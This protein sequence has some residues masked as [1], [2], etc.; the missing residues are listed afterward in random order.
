ME[1]SF[2][3]QSDSE[4]RERVLMAAEKLFR[5]RGYRAVALRD[6]AKVIGIRHT[7]LYHHF[8]QGKEE[9]FVAVTARRMENYRT[10]LARAIQE[11]GGDWLERLRAAANWLLAQE[12]MHLGRMMQADMPQISAE[13]AE[14]LRVI[15]FTSLI[16]PLEQVFRDALA[17]NPL[18]RQSSSTLAGMFLSL[19]EGIDNL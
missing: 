13:A 3:S 5:E 19:I 16:S 6:I 2:L 11:V 10:G 15:V 8:P 17:L 18:K 9:L 4:A 1:R 14:K 7:S 12:A